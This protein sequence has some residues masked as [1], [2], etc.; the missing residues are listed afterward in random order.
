MYNFILT[1]NHCVE[2]IESCDSKMKLYIDTHISHIY[3]TNIKVVKST[4]E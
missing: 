3:I 1:E 4:L 2:C